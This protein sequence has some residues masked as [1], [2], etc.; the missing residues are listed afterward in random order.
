MPPL[1]IT[2]FSLFVMVIC[3]R[4]AAAEMPLLTFSLRRHSVYAVAALPIL[5]FAPFTLIA[6][7]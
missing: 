4:Y 2:P 6:A 5:I 7:A 3:L 1:L